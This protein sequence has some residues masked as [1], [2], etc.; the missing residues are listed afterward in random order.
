MKIQSLDQETSN[1]TVQ[2]WLDTLGGLFADVSTWIGEQPG[3]SVQSSTKEIVEEA[4]GSYSAPVLTINA[5]NG[6]LILEP[7]A[8]IVFGGTGS[9]E[10]YAWPTL[11]RVRLLRKANID[12]WLILTDSGITLKQ[13]WNK[14]TFIGLARD[15]LGAS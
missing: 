15:L 10:L 2:E 5:D 13:P 14:E 9:V 6:R 4:L 1:Q 7:I 8:R 12:G 11:Y 3:W